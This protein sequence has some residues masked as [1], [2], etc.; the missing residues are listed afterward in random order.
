MGRL[1]RRFLFCHDRNLL[2]RFNRF[3]AQPLTPD[4]T[5][6]QYFYR[7]RQGHR[8]NWTEQSPNQQTPDENRNNH[9]HRVKTDRIADD[10]GRV[11]QALQILDDDKN[12]GDS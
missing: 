12:R 2:D 10:A 3:L 4:I 1:S 8:Q 7:R 11:K 6:E 9:C 5:C